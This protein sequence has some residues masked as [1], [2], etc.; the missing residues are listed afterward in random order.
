MPQSLGLLEICDFPM[1]ERLGSGFV[2]VLRVPND[3]SSTAQGG[4]GSF[5]IGNL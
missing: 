1:L 2:L 5:R 4:G 3:T